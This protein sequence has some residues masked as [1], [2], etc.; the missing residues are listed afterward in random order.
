VYNKNIAGSTGTLEINLP[1][2]AAGIYTVVI[3]NTQEVVTQKI[4]VQ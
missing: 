3:K 2:L 1:A 4:V